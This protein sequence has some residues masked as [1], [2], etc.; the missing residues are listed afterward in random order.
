[1]WVESIRLTRKETSFT[2]E[3]G[4]EVLG[5]GF[6]L[7]EREP[8]DG[9]Y[10]VKVAGVSHRRGELQEAAFDPGRELAL[11]PE[12]DNPHDPDAVGVWDASRAHQV[13]YLPR[14]RA[15]LIGR[16]LRSGRVTQAISL[17][18]WRQAGSGERVSLEILVAPDVEIELEG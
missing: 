14:D 7:P 6:W 9:F 15:R 18:E 8:P 11:V 17:W 4:N 16:R 12:P 5:V 3:A 13:G 10:R 1:M 2:G